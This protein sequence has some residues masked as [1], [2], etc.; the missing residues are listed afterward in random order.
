MM[1]KETA[2]QNPN[3]TDQVGMTLRDYMAAKAMTAA[4]STM[5]EMFL[6][7]VFDDWHR[8]GVEALAKEAY[9]IADAML[10]AR[11]KA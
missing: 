8:E 7:D 6:D 9:V 10:A 2:F 3:R 1:N 5:Y 11:E 4:Y